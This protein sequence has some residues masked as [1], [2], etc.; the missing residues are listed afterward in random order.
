MSPFI[1]PVHQPASICGVGH[2]WAVGDVTNLEF[3]HSV[4][5][6]EGS[7]SAFKRL[8]G[9]PAGREKQRLGVDHNGLL[10]TWYLVRIIQ[11]CRVQLQFSTNHLRQFSN[12]C[13]N[14]RSDIHKMT[15]LIFNN[16]L[17]GASNICSVDPI[18]FVV[19]RMN[20]ELI[21][22][23][24]ARYQSR[25]KSRRR[26]PE[27]EGGNCRGRRHAYGRSPAQAIAS[28]IWPVAAE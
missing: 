2:I 17:R 11:E 25:N 10:M 14:S 20:R 23:S 15:K 26:C 22:S 12:A 21:S 19:W 5:L 24:E 27:P 7:N 18:Q 6:S 3:H 13:R 9:T 16:E 1:G 28:R 4:S 8:C